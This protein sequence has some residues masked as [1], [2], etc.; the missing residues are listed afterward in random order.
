[1]LSFSL[2]YFIVKREF[3]RSRVH[4]RLILQRKI[5]ISQFIP[6]GDIELRVVYYNTTHTHTHT[7][8][9]LYT[10]FAVEKLHL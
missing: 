7:Y 10:S 6:P 2:I 8:N 5:D 4:S 1:M 9:M 3:N